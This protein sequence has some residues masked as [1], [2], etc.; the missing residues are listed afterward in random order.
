MGQLANSAEFSG[1]ER[2]RNDLP[3]GEY[4]VYGP[5]D[6]WGHNGAALPYY[7][8]GGSTGTEAPDLIGGGPP[9]ARVFNKHGDVVPGSARGMHPDYW[10]EQVVTVRT[11][12]QS[13]SPV[14]ITSTK[15]ERSQGSPP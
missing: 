14:T 8:T 9:G 10:E 12:A 2:T 6:T 11:Y 3:Y 7:P 1:T 5:R 13:A 15:L 4:T